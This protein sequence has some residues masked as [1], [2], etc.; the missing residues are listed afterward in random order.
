ELGAMEEHDQGGQ[1]VRRDVAVAIAFD[2]RIEALEAEIRILRDARTAAAVAP[3]AAVAPAAAMAAVAAMA[4]VVALAPVAAV[5]AVAPVA[6]LAP[7]AAVVVPAPVAAHADEAPA[8]ANSETLEQ[9]VA[10]GFSRDASAE[11]LSSH[12]GDAGV[13][14][15]YM[16]ASGVGEPPVSD[17]QTR[18]LQAMGFTGDEAR[19]AL[20]THGG[21]LE[22]ALEALLTQLQFKQACRASPGC[23]KVSF[24]ADSDGDFLPAS[25]PRRESDRKRPADAGEG[26]ES[27]LPKRKA[28]GPVDGAADVSAAEA[29]DS[30]AAGEEEPEAAA[31]PEVR[32]PEAPEQAGGAKKPKTGGAKGKAKATAKTNSKA[33]LTGAVAVVFQGLAARSQAVQIEE[34]PE[35]D[36]GSSRRLQLA[37]AEME[38]DNDLVLQ[39]RIRMKELLDLEKK[40]WKGAAGGARF[41]R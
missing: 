30:E 28:F 25:P 21:H 16:L 32:A 5:V 27:S 17:V 18:Q 40:R 19:A 8:E 4:P 7:V 20:D 34:C 1:Q 3:V 37:F 31:A 33:N 41:G 11:A 12:A 6:A 35:I 15:A 22:R 26:S 9:L 39:G 36:V 13:A 2:A 24:E 29:Q 10:M 38:P 23:G 14:V